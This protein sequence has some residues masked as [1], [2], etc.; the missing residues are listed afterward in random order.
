VWRRFPHPSRR[1]GEDVAW[2]KAVI[3]A[4][5]A[6]VFEPR[7]TVVHSHDDGV[8]AEFK[9]IYM[10]HANLH[11]LF[12]LTTVPTFR[13]AWRNSRAQV[14]VYRELVASLGATGSE[15]RRLLRVARATAFA[16]TFAQ[17]LGARSVRKG[18]PRAAFRW[19]ER[20]AAG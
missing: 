1:F 15:R 13:D 9:R 10:D 2:G 17:W 5:L 11:E 14:G 4:G 8:L 18:P 12:E 20:W 7:S 16:E 19:I 6:I 3:E